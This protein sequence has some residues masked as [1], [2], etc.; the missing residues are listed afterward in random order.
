MNILG[1]HSSLNNNEHDTGAALICDGEFLSIAEE[2]RFSRV[3]MAKGMLPYRSIKHCLQQAGLKITDIDLIVGPNKSKVEYGARIAEYLK[4]YFGY[5][6]PVELINHQLAHLSSAFFSS[7][8]KQ[9]LVISY[10]HSGDGLSAALAVADIKTGIEIIREIPNSNSLGLFYRMMTQFLGFKANDGEYKV[11]GLAAYGKPEF[12]LNCILNLRE[13]GYLLNQEYFRQE[14]VLINGDEPNYSQKLVKLLGANRLAEDPIEQR[15]MNIAYAAQSLLEQ[16]IIALIND[17]YR[18]NPISSVC[19][20]GGVALNCSANQKIAQLPFV[21]RLFVQPAASD[22][23]LAMGCALY[24]AHKNM[25]RLT[26]L[27]HCYLCGPDYSESEIEKALLLSGYTYS[28]VSSPAE[29]AAEFIAKGKIIGWFQGRS[30]F[31]P[32]ALGHRSILADPRNPGMKEA[33]NQRV[34]FREEFR[35]FAPAVLVERANDYFE[36]GT[37]DESPFMTVA[38]SV[39]KG[40]NKIIPSV[41]HVNHTARVQTVSKKNDP[42]FYQLIEKFADITGVPVVLNTSFNV[43]GQPIV[44][45]PCDAIATFASSGIDAMFLGKYLVAKRTDVL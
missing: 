33:I 35:P 43:R 1:V 5:S 19:L 31:G 27:E 7:G 36:M 3:K 28:R 34:K 29:T 16:S 22:R 8:E 13:N 39:R 24:A 4:H 23:G 42:L 10:D 14:P 15:H 44:E 17:L 38:F 40:M 6:P 30:E 32:R 26:K 12:D 18:L 25:E 9:S 41:T 21:K 2:E 45:T 37:M 20:A 11:M